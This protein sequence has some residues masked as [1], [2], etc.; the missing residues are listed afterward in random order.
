MEFERKR[1]LQRRPPAAAMLKSEHRIEARTCLWVWGPVAERIFVM[2]SQ[3]FLLNE[4]I[5]SSHMY[6]A[7]S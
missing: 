4:N 1:S 5:D 2:E 6:N 3:M 7:F